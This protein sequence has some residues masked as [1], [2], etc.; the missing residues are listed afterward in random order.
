MIKGH[1]SPPGGM[2]AHKIKILFTI[3]N[4][5]VTQVL[6][7]SRKTRVYRAV[8]LESPDSS[9]IIKTLNLEAPTIEDLAPIRHEYK[10]L[11]L[12]QGAEGIVH[13]EQLESFGAGMPPGKLLPICVG[14]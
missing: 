14:V 7:E 3:G 6:Y 9:F 4:Y 5:S 13:V 2:D 8:S 1:F 11:K 12:L 10:I